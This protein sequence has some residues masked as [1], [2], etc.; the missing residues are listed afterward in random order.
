MT[1]ASPS[2]IFHP[3][4]PA[5]RDVMAAMRT[6]L[7][8]NKG[9]LLR[10]PEARPEFDAVKLFTPA[11]SGV[12]YEAGTVGG[13]AGWW[14]RPAT[15][16][17]PD[18]AGLFLHGGAYVLGSAAAFCN[19]VS[20]VAGRVG[21]ECF[22]PDYRLAPEYPF[23]AAVNDAQAVYQGLVALGKRR[24]ALCGDSAGGGLA[25]VLLALATRAAAGQPG[26]VV[27]RAAVVLSPWTDL[28]LA[29]E[30]MQTRAAA[31]F[32]L[33]KQALATNADYYLHDHD[34]HDPLASPVY[35][36]L[37]GLPPVQV[38]VGDAEVL[39]DDSVR[40]VERARAA[41]VTAELHVWEGLTHV[42][43]GSVG[44]L[45]AAGQA[46]DMAG[47]FLAAQLG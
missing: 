43:P 10:G 23:P 45:A 34:T 47:V 13:V 28:A 44:T 26:A 18:Q 4:A 30:S 8:P 40:Y 24:I 39:L 6:R 2:T 11:F 12:T 36:D 41:G 25:L 21:V 46:L 35:G 27:P 19:L 5:D 33:T 37:A 14:C 15:P 20:Q 16:G 7:E 3:L 29:S 32:L 22:V 17:A 31:D 38:H 9:R 42:F 1:S